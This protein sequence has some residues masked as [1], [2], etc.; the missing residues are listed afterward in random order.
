M[1]RV[2]QPVQPGQVGD[3]AIHTAKQDFQSFDVPLLKGNSDALKEGAAGLLG[4]RDALVESKRLDEDLTLLE[5]QETGDARAREITQ[6]QLANM[7]GNAIGATERAQDLY[8]TL[9]DELG[10]GSGMPAAAAIAHKKYLRGLQNTILSPVA[11][12]E[13]TQKQA[14]AQKMIDTSIAS[15]IDKGVSGYMSDETLDTQI[16]LIEQRAKNRAELSA[17][18]EDA[19]QLAAELVGTSTSTM[20]L[21]AIKLALKDKKT[22]RAAQLLEDARTKNLLVGSNG[23]LLSAE[24]AVNATTQDEIALSVGIDLFG[25]HGQDSTAAL[26]ELDARTDL[27]AATKNAAEVKYESRRSK[28]DAE[29]TRATQDHFEG[30]MEAAQGGN[31]SVSAAD[32]ALMEGDDAR[33]VQLEMQ[34]WDDD[35][36]SGGI[37]TDRTAKRAWD[38]MSKTERGALTYVQFLEQYGNKFSNID[39]F[40]DKAT[41]DWRLAQDSRLAT[42][43]TEGRRLSKLELAANKS[44]ATN[45][46]TSFNRIV[47]ARKTAMY[48][49]TTASDKAHKATFVEAAELEFRDRNT[50][51]NPMSDAD[52]MSMINALTNR[53]TIG[54]DEF[55]T[56]NVITNARDEDGDVLKGSAEAGALMSGVD[57]EDRFEVI[58][59]YR[60]EHGISANEAVRLEDVGAYFH[61]NITM[62]I[63]PAELVPVI[64]EMLVEHGRSTS[65]ANVRQEYLTFLMRQIREGAL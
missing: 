31:G 52:M 35:R 34:Y 23:D 4:V 61:D 43:T 20:Y 42:E 49:G 50:N 56:F 58:Q 53:I 45:A 6:G 51:E 2:P 9:V 10:D 47:E 39:G 16:D 59:W 62:S 28:A 29:K 60:K 19:K 8:D 54:G 33:K 24:T 41:E 22:V 26:T 21:Q 13:R 15:S 12:H 18:G 11:S 17:S 5:T 46:R 36:A 38:G 55:Q 63:T 57:V 27:D 40:R 44:A 3:V 25:T 7:G 64:H 48:T 1:P 37:I 14:H 30:A 32:L 65:A